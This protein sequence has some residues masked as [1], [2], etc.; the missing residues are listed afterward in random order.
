[1]SAWE[2]IA[3][4]GVVVCVG[5]LILHIIDR[6]QIHWLETSN[7][8]LRVSNDILSKRNE[9]QR[10][11]LEDDARLAFIRGDRKDSEIKALKVELAQIGYLHQ[12]MNARDKYINRWAE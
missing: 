10:E 2:A 4:L 11:C 1:M 9:R 7:A 5:L 6:W 8:A 3:L 12:W